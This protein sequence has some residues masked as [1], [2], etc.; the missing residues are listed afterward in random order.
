MHN[1][2]LRDEDLANSFNKYFSTFV[3]SR[4][5]AADKHSILQNMGAPNVKSA[6]LDPT[7]LQ[8]VYSTV[9]GLKNTK[10]RDIDDL[11]F[12]PIEYVLDVLVPAFTF[13][14]TLCLSTGVFP[15][16]MQHV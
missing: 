11:Q 14:F 12:R 15:E 6:F 8:E 7:T 5:P 4:T 3:S 16:K 10:G 2:I 9:R 13:L 1:K